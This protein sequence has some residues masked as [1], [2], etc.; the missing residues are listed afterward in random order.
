MAVKTFER[1][2]KKLST[3]FTNLIEN[4]NFEEYDFHS[5]RQTLQDYI[6]QTYPNYNDYFRS[7]YVI[8]LIELFAFYGEMMAYRMDVNMNEAYLSSAKERKN[9]IKIADML[10]YKYDRIDP[11]QSI[12]KIDICDTTPGGSDF[13]KKIKNQG[14]V[15]DIL[16]KTS[17]IT[18]APSPSTTAKYYP[19]RLDFLLKNV[20]AED[21]MNTVEN[22]FEKLEDFSE[23]KDI[24]TKRI[25]IDNFEYYERSIFVDKF[26]MRFDANTNVDI[27][28]MRES[29]TFEIQSLDYDPV[30]YFNTEKTEDALTYNP[31]TLYNEQVSLGFEMVLRYDKGNNI[32]D[33]NIYMYVPTVQ[34]G[35]FTR[36]IDVPKAI[37]NFKMIAYEKNIFNNPTL[38]R[39]FDDQGNL[40]RTYNEVENLANNPYKYA[41]EVNNT[42]DGH[43]ELNF[44]DGKNSEIL[45]QSASTLLYYR[46]NLHNTDEIMNIINGDLDFIN[47]PIKYFDSHVGQTQTTALSLELPENFTAK[48]GLEAESDEQ[49]KYMARKLRSIQ[50]RFVTATDY[51]T[52]GMLHPR[53]KYTTVVLRSYIGKNSPRLSNEFLDVYVDSTKNNISLFNLVGTNKN[54]LLTDTAYFTESSVVGE[55]DSIKFVNTNYSYFFDIFDYQT[56][57]PNNWFKYSEEMILS[58]NKGTIIELTNRKLDK[59]MF[60]QIFV[61]SIM[62][63]VLPLDYNIAS[64]TCKKVSSTSI[65]FEIDLNNTIKFEEIEININKFSSKILEKMN[66]MITEISFDVLKISEINS[67]KLALNVKYKTDDFFIPEDLTYVWTHYKSDDIYINPSKSNIIEIYVTGIK[68]D[69]KK[70]ISTYAPLT[71]SEINK[72]IRDIEE[73]KMISDVVQVYNAGIYEIEVALRIFKLHSSSI[74]DDLLRSKVSTVIDEFFDIENI[75]LGKHFHFSKLIEWIHTKVTEVQHIEVITDENNNVITPS[76]TVDIL[77]DKIIFT[78]IIEKKQLINNK[79]V[80]VRT[81]EIVS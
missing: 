66:G 5:I 15:N 79:N 78:Q 19:Y 63:G 72:L 54:F 33:K 45:L 4:Y 48:G 17:D 46:K 77:S 81:I 70:N 16:S 28:Y 62:N 12:N 32:I 42:Q 50:D 26:L 23:N 41:Y 20:T 7:D 57:S 8:M 60:D 10:G 1:E 56:V 25:L 21:F 51:E 75:P 73:R 43:I 27:A 49:I 9:I 22:I 13:L 64:F 53:V 47:L 24:K 37:K 36:P 3:E 34:G 69:L 39:Q 52:A 68:K 2:V 38:V 40:L 6:E 65:Y 80:P 44:G 71:S 29:K 14:S 11:A 18:F 67:K 31:N 30:L 74:T 76:S 61:S 35:T 59:S 58:K 55:H